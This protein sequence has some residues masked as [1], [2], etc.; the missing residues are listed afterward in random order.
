MLQLGQFDLQFSFKTSGALRKYIKDQ[1]HTI[2]YP[3][4]T[5]FLYIAFLSWAKDMI[6]DDDIGLFFHHCLF[7]LFYLAAT[8]KKTSIWCVSGT[9]NRGHRFEPGRR[10][11]LDEFIKTFI[12]FSILKIDINENGQLAD[13]CLVSQ[14]STSNPEYSTLNV[15]GLVLTVLMVI[16]RPWELD[17]SSWNN[18]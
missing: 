5:L 6:E 10:H 14:I 3:A 18:G 12:E 9:G 11:Q 8:D 15:S 7:D 4:L 13:S 16:V 17:V 1:A 2:N